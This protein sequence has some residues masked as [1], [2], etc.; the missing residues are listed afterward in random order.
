[1]KTVKSI[2]IIAA[3]IAASLVATSVS[4]KALPPCVGRTC[5]AA[6]QRCAA[7]RQSHGISP[8]VLT[9]E[10]SLAACRNTGVWHGKFMPPGL[11]GGCTVEGR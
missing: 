9:C 4:V 2:L 3:V 1:M 11:E 10:N 7:Y 6:F 8:S 5:D